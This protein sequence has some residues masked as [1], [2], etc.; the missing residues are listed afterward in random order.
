MGLVLQSFRLLGFF[1]IFSKKLTFL[2]LKCMLKNPK[3]SEKIFKNHII[4][5]KVILKCPVTFLE[6]MTFCAKIMDEG[7]GP[8]G[9]A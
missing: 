4:P 9:S 5:Y 6:F 7:G 2:W 8:G 3:K 1:L